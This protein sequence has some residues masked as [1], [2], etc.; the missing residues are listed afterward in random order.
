MIAAPAAPRQYTYAT[1]PLRCEYLRQAALFEARTYSLPK[2]MPGGN[3]VIYDADDWTHNFKRGKV[4]RYS[5]FTGL[6]TIH[7]DSMAEGDFKGWEI[8]KAKR[9]L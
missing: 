9:M 2:V 1:V 3:A 6:H 4:I 5:Y 7:F 8:I